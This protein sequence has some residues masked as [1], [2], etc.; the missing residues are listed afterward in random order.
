[1][2]TNSTA[3]APRRRMR[4]DEKSAVT[5]DGAADSALPRWAKGASA[6]VGDL[7][8]SPAALRR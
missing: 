2:P 4:R 5:W 3:T 8:G 1:M 6:V 7:D